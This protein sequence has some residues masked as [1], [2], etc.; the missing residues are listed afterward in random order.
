MS[1]KPRISDVARRARVS[2]GT[3]SHVLTGS[4]NVSAKRRARVEKAIEDLGYVP[5]FHAQG[6][7]RSLS[8]VVGICFPHVSTAYLNELSQ[9]LEEIASR[10]GY[11]VMHVFSRHD[12]A[13]ELDRVK[14]LVRYRVDGLILLPSS[15]P[16]K[17]L[18]FAHRKDVPLVIVDRPTQDARFDH[19]LLDNRKAMREVGQRLID[20]GHTRLLFVFRSHTRLVTQHR[21][22]GLQA[23]RATAGRKV[24]VQCIEF[25]N[26]AQFLRD[27]LARILRAPA[28][29]TAIIASNSHHAALV[30]GFLRELGIQV[31]GDTS[32]VS[33][34]DAEWSRLVVPRLSVIRQ[35]AMA[36]AEAAWELLMQRVNRI[37]GARRTVALD[38]AIDL[39]ESVA[40]PPGA[41]TADGTAGRPT[42][43]PYSV[44]PI[45]R[46][47]SR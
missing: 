44:T 18:D 20:L 1:R 40:P 22:K 3:V 39:R 11:G 26:D 15:A 37:R 10:D 46:A 42:S 35:P 25:Q 31:P 5:N 36:M 29:P 43:R 21:L 47:T 41:Q 34:D 19:V 12:P 27:E 28:A 38:A 30:L 4:A 8:R 33:F 14:E 13:T 2:V 32:V 17:A 7:R 24:D 6:L 16:A 9:T 23:A 45:R